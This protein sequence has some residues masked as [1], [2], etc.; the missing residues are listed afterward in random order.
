LAVL[1]EACHSHRVPILISSAGGDGE[2][3]HVD[4]FVD[5]ITKL[6]SKHGFRSLNVLSIYP[7]VPKDL[8]REKLDEG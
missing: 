7:E 8:V 5:I 4:M 2:N 6:I 3:G 1:V